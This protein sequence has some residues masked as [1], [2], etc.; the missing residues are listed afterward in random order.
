MIA[1]L[2]MTWAF[3]QPSVPNAPTMGTLTVQ[4]HLP[5]EVLVDGHKIVQLWYPGTASFEVTP[6]PR[7]VRLYIGGEATDTPIVFQEG[8]AVT[9]MVGRTGVTVD[10]SVTADDAPVAAVE[11]VPVEF[12][13]VDAGAQLRIDD[14]RVII[15]PGS[16]VAV[17]LALGN[18]RV[19]FRNHDGTVI[20]ATG[21]LQVQAG[22]KL[23]VQV[24]DGRLP[25]LFGA[26]RFHATGG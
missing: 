20:W 12:R 9:L 4:A 11:A 10:E 1:T 13:C 8:E 7:V 6:G 16:T 15:E 5:T 19:S 22:E 24:S 17:D 23:V 26:G 21:T 2:W 14:E 3:A 25:E 18:H